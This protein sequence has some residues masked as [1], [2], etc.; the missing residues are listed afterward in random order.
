MFGLCSGCFMSFLLTFLSS[1]GRRKSRL[2][3]VKICELLLFCLL[4]P[5]LQLRSGLPLWFLDEAILSQRSVISP[6]F[7]FILPFYFFFINILISSTICLCYFVIVYFSC[8]WESIIRGTWQSLCLKKDCALNISIAHT[9]LHTFKTSLSLFCVPGCCTVRGVWLKTH[10]SHYYS[11]SC[12]L[13]LPW[14]SP[15]P[16]WCMYCACSVAKDSIYLT[17]TVLHT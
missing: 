17:S 2:G 14:T 12:I 5:S 16:W 15:V 4:F 1:Q 9:I 13:I 3:H 6:S 11:S 10:L 7:I 8:N